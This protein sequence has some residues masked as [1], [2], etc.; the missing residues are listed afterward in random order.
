MMDVK[1]EARGCG[2]VYV[3]GSTQAGGLDSHGG[4]IC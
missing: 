1:V 4:G 2:E 3:G